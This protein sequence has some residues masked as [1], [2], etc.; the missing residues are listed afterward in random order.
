MLQIIT[1]LSVGV[2]VGILNGAAGG[3]S[4]LS[5]P[6]LVAAG[7][8]PVSA[9]MTNAIGV[10]PA[11]IFAL[12]G[13]REKVLPIIKEHSKLLIA[14]SIGAFIGA[15]ALAIL[16]EENFK[17]IV[18]FLLLIASFSLLINVAPALTAFERRL[19]ILLMTAIGI[20]CGYFGPGQGV[21]VIA[22]LARDAGRAIATVNISKNVIVAI[23]NFF[24]NVVFIISGHVDWKFAFTL[25]IGASGGG[26]IGGRLVGKV[27][28]NVYKSIIFTVGFASA[29]WF[30]YK[31]WIK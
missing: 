1:I 5:F 31:Y 20:Y 17:K 18:P 27:S 29:L 14:A 6:V 10:F 11:N 13:K 25:F 8:N 4:I 7:L 21:M 23:S 30:F 16:P 9:A 24:S 22:V 19:E 3:A 2:L 12:V 15:M 26:Y 28:R